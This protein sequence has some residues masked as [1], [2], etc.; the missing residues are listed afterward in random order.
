MIVERFKHEVA[1]FVLWRL[2]HRDERFIHELT[3]EMP[4]C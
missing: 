1:R 4:A 3:Q 2:F